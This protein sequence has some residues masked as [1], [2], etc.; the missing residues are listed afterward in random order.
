[1]LPN[2][3]LCNLRYHF[4]DYEVLKHQRNQIHYVYLL[5]LGIFLLTAHRVSTQLVLDIYRVHIMYYAATHS[6]ELHSNNP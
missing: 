3:F 5:I 6:D 4:Q 2:D 1:M